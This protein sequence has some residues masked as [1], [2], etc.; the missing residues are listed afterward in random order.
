LA[1][2][3]VDSLDYSVF[4]NFDGNRIAA[5]GISLDEGNGFGL[6]ENPTCATWLQPLG[7]GFETPGGPTG[8]EQAAENSVLYQGT[9]LVGP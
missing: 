7:Y 4:R 2:E 1:F 8:A 6:A 9:T 3:S 5:A